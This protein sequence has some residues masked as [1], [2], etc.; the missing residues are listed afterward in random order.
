[1]KTHLVTI[2]EM[3]MLNGE[4]CLRFDHPLLDAIKPGQFLQ[5]F[6]PSTD[7]LLPKL[8]HPC[9]SDAGHPFF[10]G[11]VVRHWQPGTTLHIRGPRGNGFHLPPLAR[12]IALAAFDINGVNRLLPL[13]R[14]ALHAGAAVSLVTDQELDDLPAEI[15]LLPLAEIENLKTW[16]DYA[17]FILPPE[18]IEPTRQALQFTPGRSAACEVEIQVDVPMICDEHSNCGVCGVQ[19][20]RGWRLACK[21][22]PVFGLETLV[23]GE[24]AHG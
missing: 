24:L 23:V 13:A 21:D 7:T 22:G 16:A 19:T 14:V 2:T 3:M 4:A 17:A 5:V 18:K 1:M 8:L 10:C 12:N 6:D 9:G 11:E 20:T 15:E